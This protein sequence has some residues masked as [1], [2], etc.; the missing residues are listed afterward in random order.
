M[1]L[2]EWWHGYRAFWPYY[3]GEHRKPANRLL[4]FGGTTLAVVSLGLGI[5]HDP[6]FLAAVPIAGYGPAWLGHFAVERNRPATFRRPFYSLI[7]D[8]HM[9]ALM[10]AGRMDREIE[11]LGRDGRLPA[12]ARSLDPR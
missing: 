10:W 5:A 12:P 2:G 3:V 9:Y 4:H 7:G 6:W 11:R 1:P 8:F